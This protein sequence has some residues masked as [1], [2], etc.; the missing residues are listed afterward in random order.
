MNTTV[1]KQQII[2]SNTEQWKMYSKLKGK[3][4]QI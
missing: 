4:Y 3:E 2:T 1:E